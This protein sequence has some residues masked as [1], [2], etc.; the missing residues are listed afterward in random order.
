MIDPAHASPAERFVADMAR[1]PDARQAL[2]ELLDA[3]TPLQ[4]SVLAHDWEGFW[5]RPKQLPPEGSWSS[6]GQLTGTGFGKNRANA[7]AINIE[8]LEGR[9]RCIGL[10]GQTEDRTRDMMVLDG[11]C[12]LI[13]TSPLWHRARLECGEVRWPNGARAYL[14]SPEAVGAIHGHSHD[15]FWASEIHVWPRHSMLQA[16]SMIDLGVRKGDARLIWDSNPSPRHPIL[17]ELIARAEKRPHRHKI[18][19]GTVYENVTNLNAAKLEDW[20]DKW[21]GTAFGRMMLDGEQ[22]DEVDGATY[23]QAWIDRAR[24]D[25]PASL[26]RRILC[27]DPAVSTREGC[28]ATGIIEIGIDDSGQLY[29]LADHSGHHEAEAWAAI[30]LDTYVSHRCDCI[31][32]ERNR[33]GDLCVQAIRGLARER[34]LR[35]E[36][37]DIDA[38]TRHAQGVI[39]VK[40]IHSRSDKTTRALPT[41]PIYEHGLVSHVIGVDLGDLETEMTTF[42]PGPKVES[43]N[44]LDALVFGLWE[45]CDL[46][47]EAQRDHAR[48][49]AAAVTAQDDLQRRG[50]EVRRRA[51]VGAP[52]SFGRRGL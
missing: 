1:V 52:M 51:P 13:A 33:G 34:K 36:V 7:E 14:Y 3:L 38:P 37:V 10:M 25:E 44:R 42:V 48:D 22:F 45:L 26:R 18:V 5:A 19:R 12:G 43:P 49:I 21:G 27:C 2:D 40:E 31:M 29:V 30:L 28:D 39:L 15:L 4:L 23:Q 35:V 32:V 16:W 17:R 20:I 8:V 9:A 24:R 46:G 6:W 11:D 50:S 47:R 41:A